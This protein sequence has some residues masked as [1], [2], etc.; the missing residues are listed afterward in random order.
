MTKLNI[1]K[2]IHID[3]P[4]DQV[5]E[6]I[7][8]FHHWRAWSPWL[9][10]EPAA[11]VDVREDGK[12]YTWNGDLTGAGQMEVTGEEPKQWVDYDLLFLKPWKSKA[13][14]RFEVAEKNGG[15]ET[16][17]YMDSNLPL[18]LFWM[19]K[20]MTALIGMDY[21]RGLLMLKNLVEDGE[22]PSKME[23]KGV[24]DY[25]GCKFIGVKTTCAMADVGPKMQ[26]DLTKIW[27]YIEDKQELIAGAPFSIYHKYNFA[28]GEVVYTSGLPVKEIPK[29]LVEG[30][31]SGSI[32]ATKVYTIRHTGPYQHLG[33]VWSTLQ[34]MKQNKKFKMVKRIHPFETY[35]NDP[36]Q[37]DANDLVTEVHFPI[38]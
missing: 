11:T 16:T 15:T 3:A 31:I 17:W 29:N 27:H 33:N 13:K 26:E 18:F 4:D 9:I 23:H 37:V 14:V 20:T 21:D 5:Y 6:K 10:M 22:V 7:S 34:S 35:E 36:S 8:D 28:K 32:P 25:S 2:S 30:L 24:N 12:F 1:S 19:K 38:R